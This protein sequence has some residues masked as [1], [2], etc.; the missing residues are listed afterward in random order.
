MREKNYLGILSQLVGKQKLVARIE[1]AILQMRQVSIKIN[2]RFPK[3][4]ELP[5]LMTS[6]TYGQFITSLLQMNI[7]VAQ[8]TI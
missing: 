4:E 1:H 6:T 7:H 2:I 5:N 3:N 8:Q